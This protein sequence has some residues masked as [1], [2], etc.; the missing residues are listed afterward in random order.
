MSVQ[1]TPEGKL[2]QKETYL[3]ISGLPKA[4]QDYLAKNFAGVDFEK[5]SKKTDAKG[6][7]FYQAETKDKTLLF[8]TKGNFLKEEKE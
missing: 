5:A 2:V 7:L 6:I 3:E 1:I 8:D 4:A